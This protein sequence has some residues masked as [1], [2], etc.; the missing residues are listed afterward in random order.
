[1]PLAAV[2]DD[3]FDFDRWQTAIVDGQA[4]L[5]DAAVD[6][7]L[8]ACNCAGET[9]TCLT[10]PGRTV[11]TTPARVRANARRLIQWRDGL[12]RRCA[13]SD[14]SPE[15]REQKR[16]ECMFAQAGAFSEGLAGEPDGRV[17]AALPGKIVTAIAP[18]GDGNGP[19]PVTPETTPEK[20]YSTE[21]MT[22]G[23]QICR[24]TLRLEENK[25]RLKRVL[26]QTTL[27]AVERRQ[28]E[29]ALKQSIKE[30]S[31]TIQALKKQ[32]TQLTHERFEAFTFCSDEI[33]N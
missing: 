2:A 33:L 4:A 24:L 19:D 13:R 15:E 26:R 31:E 9:D 32:F 11:P 21:A 6:D 17:L 1:M 10:L 30:L 20:A 28:R 23:K 5:A 3:C 25:G 18:A 16:R 8:T 27:P 29:M 12:D 22:I 14:A 7:A